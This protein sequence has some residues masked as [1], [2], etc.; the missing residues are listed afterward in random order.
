[1]KDEKR[2]YNPLLKEFNEFGQFHL[3]HVLA[4]IVSGGGDGVV[5]DEPLRLRV[6]GEGQGIGETDQLEPLLV[7]AVVNVF[8]FLNLEPQTDGSILALR[9]TDQRNDLW[10]TVVG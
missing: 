1:M 8:E 4:K 9:L 5:I 3:R 6:V 10:R 2:R 7:V